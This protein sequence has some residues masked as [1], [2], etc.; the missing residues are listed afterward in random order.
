MFDSQENIYQFVGTTLLQSLPDQWVV[1]WIDAS[2][3]IY[4]KR[5]AINPLYL[6]DSESNI[7]VRIDID[8]LELVK[9]FKA[10]DELF[11]LRASEKY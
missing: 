10:F 11:K 9:M 4:T 7:G 5:S 1:S 2:I 8:K 6:E 3:N